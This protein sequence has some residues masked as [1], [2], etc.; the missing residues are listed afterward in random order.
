MLHWRHPRAVKP[1]LRRTP[2]TLTFASMIQP[3]SLAGRLLLAMPGMPDP[4]FEAAVVALCI[5][6]KDGALG[7]GIGDVLDGVT[8]YNLL[9]DLDIPRGLAP[10]VEVHH[11]GPVEPQRGFVLH[12]PDWQAEGTLAVGDHWALTGSR[13]VLVAI[14][15]G[16]GPRHYLIALGYAGWGEGQLDAEMRH[17]GW[18]AAQGR[19]EI[20]FDTPT[21]ARWAQAWRAEGIDPAHLTHETGRA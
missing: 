17:H 5:H 3:Q 7:V 15:E 10:D 19:P 2:D 8:L 21:D 20:L 12:S 18:H 11:G 1:P 6:D 4:R 14:S 16:R 13:D 9:D